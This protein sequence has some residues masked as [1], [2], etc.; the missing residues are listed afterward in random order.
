MPQQC[1][2]QSPLS[3]TPPASPAPRCHHHV[4][5][6]EVDRPSLCR[7]GRPS[8]RE[9]GL[10]LPETSPKRQ[11]RQPSLHLVKAGRY[12]ESVPPP[13]PPPG[14]AWDLDSLPCPALPCPSLL[15]SRCRRHL[16]VCM[17]L[18]GPKVLVTTNTHC[19]LGGTRLL[20]SSPCPRR[21]CD[22]PPLP[23]FPFSIPTHHH[24]NP[25]TPHLP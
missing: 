14:P 16:E 25:A 19:L 7:A 20:A 17:H 10:L 13:P 22:G 18:F 23:P 2:P 5:D 1:H 9:P 6:Q 11:S 21:L 3:P 12:A 24:N 8:S 15:F 4:P